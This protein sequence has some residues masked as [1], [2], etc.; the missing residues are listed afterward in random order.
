MGREGTNER[1]PEEV[2]TGCTLIVSS[3][4]AIQSGPSKAG[5]VL[6]WISLS[7]FSLGALWM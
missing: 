2:R 5:G 4:A 3:P 7:K 1:E 6:V